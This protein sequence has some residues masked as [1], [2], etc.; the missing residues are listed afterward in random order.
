MVT[1]ET[2]SQIKCIEF[3][4]AI[5]LVTNREILHK[6]YCNWFGS[7]FAMCLLMQ[8]SV[9]FSWIK[10][11]DIAHKD[12]NQYSQTPR[13]ITYSIEIKKTMFQD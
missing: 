11:E 13:L 5:K 2:I 1:V 9:I 10:T 12:E 7:M 6:M 3:S 8:I 4:F